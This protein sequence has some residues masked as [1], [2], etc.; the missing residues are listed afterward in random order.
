MGY[1]LKNNG[2]TINLK[3]FALNENEIDSLVQ[4]VQAC[5]SDIGMQFGISK[6]SV[7]TMNHGES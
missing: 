3:L 2:P 5:C 6:C 4:T 1:K 7:L